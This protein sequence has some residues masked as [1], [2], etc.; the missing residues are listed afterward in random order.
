MDFE[1][2]DYKGRVEDLEFRCNS[3][4]HKR[5]SLLETMN[6]EYQ[7]I[8]QEAET[9]ARN[10]RVADAESPI[11]NGGLESWFIFRLNYTELQRTV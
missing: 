3:L 5:V 8:Y 6:R 4:E 2:R 7:I 11:P 10:I 9:L 1:T